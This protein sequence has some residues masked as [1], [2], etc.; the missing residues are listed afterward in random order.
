MISTTFNILKAHGACTARYRYLA[1][2]LGSVKA[3]G[4]D[5]TIPLTRVLKINGVSDTYWVLRNAAVLPGDCKKIDAARR[6]INKAWD[7]ADCVYEA[8]MKAVWQAYWNGGSRE[9][10]IRAR[11]SAHAVLLKTLRPIIAKVIKDA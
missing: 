6:V 1:K 4:A 9:A 7:K 10:Y 11:N 3:Y 8:K 5:K 2:V